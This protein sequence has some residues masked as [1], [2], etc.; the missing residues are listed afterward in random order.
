[1][2]ILNNEIPFHEYVRNVRS[3]ATSAV[4]LAIRLDHA[5]PGDLT[6]PQRGWLREVMKSAEEVKRVQSDRDRAGPARVRPLMLAC[7]SDWGAIEERLIAAER[8][9]PEIS[10]HGR[11]AKVLRATL[12]PDG[13]SFVQLEAVP[14]WHEGSRRLDR[15][16]EE[17]LTKELEEIVGKPYLEAVKKSTSELAEALGVGREPRNAPGTRALADALAKFGR[18]VGGYG[19]SLAADVDEE[20]P[21]S[22]ER[23]LKALQPVVD[24]RSARGSS[25]EP[26]AT[27]PE[28]VV[29]SQPTPAPAPTPVDPEPVA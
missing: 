5:A 13:I 29:N 16:R 25:G 17:N 22:V 11:R 7:G 1:M 18:S 24:H 14:A 19:R 28:I 23:F 2:S 12:L 3:T 26:E 6:T 10:D 4:A 21:A 27:D 9:S 15:I 20:D 8:I